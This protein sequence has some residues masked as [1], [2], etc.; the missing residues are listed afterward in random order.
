MHALLE[1]KN[2]NVSSL[3][4]NASASN[5]DQ[6]LFQAELQVISINLFRYLCN[7]LNNTEQHAL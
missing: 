2:T 1:E 5:F 7:F 6:G 4:R 3:E